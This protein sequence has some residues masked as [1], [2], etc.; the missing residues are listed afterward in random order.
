VKKT[1]RKGDMEMN[2]FEENG[3]GEIMIP[4]CNRII[5]AEMSNDYT[6]P[7]YQPEIR[8]VLGVKEHIQSTAKYISGDMAEINGNVDYTVIYVGADGE[9]YSA[10]LSAEYSASAPVA[11]VSGCEP[12]ATLAN[13][14]AESVTARVT[15][16]RKLT[17]R[18][19]L[20]CHVRAYGRTTLS[21]AISG[22][23][24]DPSSIQRLTKEGLYLSVASGMSE[25]VEVSDSADAD[26][27]CRA[28]SADAC[29]CIN[30]SVCE[31]SR[32]AVK[33]EVLIKL[34]CA[35]ESDGDYYTL[36]RRLPFSQYIELE[37]SV[38][39]SASARAKGYVDT[40]SVSLEEGKIIMGV[41]FFVGAEAT[42]NKTFGYTADLYSTK[43]YCSC[44]YEKRK[45]PTVI[46]DLS[47]KLSVSEKVSFADMNLGGAPE[48][49]DFIGRAS[50]SS[51]KWEDGRCVI[52][53]ESR[54]G[55]I[56]KHDGEISQNEVTIPFSYD[57]E[58]AEVSEIQREDCDVSVCVTSMEAKA[59]GESVEVACEL[60]LCGTVLGYGEI[61][62]VSEAV[63]GENIERGGSDIVI[64]YPSSGESSWDVAK[65]YLVA[66]CDVMGKAES[67]RYCIIQI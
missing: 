8:R 52:S 62:C 23:V 66:P 36:T 13:V 1:D 20:N 34:V 24:S 9:L 44:K 28:V 59:D 10:P 11:S 54:C 49:I 43:R 48:I 16:P 18:C 32:V 31:G 22:E 47:E 3:M 6:L 4:L 27:D 38:D 57:F 21:E 51:A 40:V 42:S 12:C 45:M 25:L 33:G 46:K 63:M 29:V 30:D 58:C 55:V 50:V 35:G 14:S 56:C 61:E 53:G 26:D 37:G 15:A 39:P 64:C 2:K 7:D 65:K 60:A 19:R 67:D 41:S 5:T 17:V